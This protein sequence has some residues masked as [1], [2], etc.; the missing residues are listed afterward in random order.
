MRN[1]SFKHTALQIV[2]Q[3]KTVTR[4]A[5]WTFAKPRMILQ[6]IVQGQGLAAGQHVQPIGCP[7]A[8]VDV[9]FVPVSPITQAEVTAE[10]FPAMTPAGFVAFFCKTM[11]AEPTQTITRLKFAYA[12]NF[13]L[14]TD[15]TRGPMLVCPIDGEPW[16]CQPSVTGRFVK[17]HAITPAQARSIPHNLVPEVQRVAFLRD[18]R[19]RHG[20]KPLWEEIPSPLDI[21]RS[22]AA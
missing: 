12:Q 5:G 9:T 19:A 14:F 10:G 17:V 7:I 15:P 11:K 13:R 2:Y 22:L 16:L 21:E 20:G 1:M 18:E 3:T 4:R 6:P 8:L